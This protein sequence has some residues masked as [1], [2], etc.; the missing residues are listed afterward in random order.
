M[1][2]LI[3]LALAPVFIIAFYIYFRDKY[4]KEPL[5]I[6]LITLFSGAI[7]SV[8][9]VLIE[10]IMSLP[11]PW[12]TGIFNSAWH[13]F[14]VASL[15][16]EGF[17]LIVLF[18]LVWKSKEFNEKFDG[19]VYSCFISLGFAGVENLLYVLNS[20]VTTGLARALTAVPAHAIF[21]VTMGYFFAIAK[22]YPKKKKK[23]LWMSFLIPF[24]LHG[25][26]DFIL[27]SGINYLLLIFVPFVIYMWISGF[28]RMKTFNLS[29]V[30]RNDL[31]IGID[32]SKVNEYKKGSASKK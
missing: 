28:N 22:F 2:G 9:V 23:Y 16:E 3:I 4:E 8:P 17:K 27:M 13:A 12:L 21:G 1:N 29:S 24:I 25:F 18:L 14:M 10:K 19:I 30:Y 5:S 6:L 26:Y 15:C 20:G 31:D 11:S 32:F 7:I